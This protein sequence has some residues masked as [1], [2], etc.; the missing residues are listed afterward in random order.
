MQAERKALALQV[1]ALA[2][3]T[4]IGEYELQLRALTRGLALHRLTSQNSRT[5]TAT[6]K[7]VARSLLASGG[8]G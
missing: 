5:T 4:G 2:A 1:Q 6:N 7:P 8:G 3:K